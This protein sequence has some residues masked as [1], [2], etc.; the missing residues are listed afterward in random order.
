MEWLT[1]HSLDQKPRLPFLSY[2]ANSGLPDGQATAEF[3]ADWPA[4][5]VFLERFT[6]QRPQFINSLDFIEA[7]DG[8]AYTI[9]LSENADAGLWTDAEESRNSFVWSTT[10]DASP[11]AKNT[12]PFVFPINGQRGAGDG[13]ISYARPSSYHLSSV[14]GHSIKGV[15]VLYCDGHT[16]FIEEQLDPRL[17]VALLTPDGT[18]LKTPGSDQVLETPFREE[19]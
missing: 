14:N 13:S 18:Q 9:A 17:Y 1:R 5:G 12:M 2:V 19:R 15:Y 11:A 10:T 16:R 6:E 7:H 3:P 4:N 8:A